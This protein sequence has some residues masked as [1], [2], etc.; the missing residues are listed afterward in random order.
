MTPDQQTAFRSDVKNRV[1][2]DAAL[3]AAYAG[4]QCDVIASLMSVGRTKHGPTQIG[5]GTI[6][7]ALGDP[8]GGMF[9]DAVEQL[10]QTD[11]TTYWG[12][13]PV[14]R[15]VLDLSVPAAPAFLASLKSKLPDYASD[16]DK[17]LLIGVVADPVNVAD[18]HTALFEFNGTPK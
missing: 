9:L 2:S 16:I 18:V 1:Q 3:A 10:G 6:V 13:D 8:R 7:V 12:M 5:S 4:K 14:R 17:L 15:G 11:R